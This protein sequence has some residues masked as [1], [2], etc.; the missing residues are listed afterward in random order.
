MAGTRGALTWL[1]SADDTARILL[2]R[3]D[4]D[5]ALCESCLTRLTAL[6]LLSWFGHVATFATPCVSGL[7]VHW[8][9][10]GRL[11]WDWDEAQH[12]AAFLPTLGAGVAVLVLNIL[13]WP[14]P[15]VQQR[16]HG[17]AGFARALVRAC[18]AHS[19]HA[20]VQYGCLLQLGSAMSGKHGG[21]AELVRG[22]G[23]V[24]AA[25][26]A[27]RAHPTHAGIRLEALSLLAN[28]SYRSEVRAHARTS[29]G[30]HTPSH[31][32]TGTRARTPTPRHTERH[33]RMHT[34]TH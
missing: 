32:H 2:E 23:G 4:A 17:R 24:E 19:R 13:V 15:N 7:M 34:H 31:W 8:H 29:A 22:A 14:A 9:W 25:C 6:M 3:A 20:N 5:A 21:D 28:L 16:V 12:W 10:H 27:L 11:P 1:S 30:A 26:A 18:V 33:A